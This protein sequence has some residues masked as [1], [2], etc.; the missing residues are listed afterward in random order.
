MDIGDKPEKFVGSRQWIG[1]TELGFCLETMFGINSRILTTN[2]GA[3]I[4]EHARSL[5]FHFDNYGGP[6]MIGGG[7]L[8]HTILG[9]DYNTK[10]GECRYLI[11]DPH[12]TSNEN[13]QT[14][15]SGGWCSWKSAGFWS[16][17]DYYNLLLPLTVPLLT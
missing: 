1:S 13:M 10:S 16:K 6:V 5:L 8:A 7:Q 9:I 4:G 3:E 11:L 12:Y 2:S 17:T 15:I 14:V